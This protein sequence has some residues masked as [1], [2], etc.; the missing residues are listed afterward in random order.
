MQVLTTSGSIKSTCCLLIVA[1]LASLNWSP[2]QTLGMAWLKGSEPPPPHF[3]IQE[4]IGV[5]K[6]HSLSNQVISNKAKPR[7]GRQEA[8][9]PIQNLLARQS[10]AVKTSLLIHPQGY[11]LRWCVSAQKGP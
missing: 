5:A 2:L 3:E 9:E 1:H 8:F 4:W 11:K 7:G 6:L 10:A